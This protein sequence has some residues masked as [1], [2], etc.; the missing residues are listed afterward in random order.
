MK[1]TTFLCRAVAALGFFR[2]G[3]LATHADFLTGTNG[4]R[5]VGTIVEETATNVVFDSEL[6]G[7]LTFPG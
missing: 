7:R 5:F 1:R 2:L 4:E 6:A 3:L